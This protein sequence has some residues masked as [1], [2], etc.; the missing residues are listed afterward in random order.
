MSDAGYDLESRESINLLPRDVSIVWTGTWVEIPVGHCGLVLPRS[1]LA[2][3]GITIMNAP[4]L[5]DSG[6]RGEIGVIL[7][8]TMSH[9]S[10][11]IEPGNRIAQLVIMP[12]L[13]ICFES[14]Q[15]LGESERGKDGYGSTGR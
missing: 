14:V 5:I 11:P 6:Y 15:Q 7:H 2:T 1:G 8:N 13:N 4:G 10:F 3:Q 12:T 9:T